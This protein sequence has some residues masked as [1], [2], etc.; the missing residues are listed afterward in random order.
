MARNKAIIVVAHQI[1]VIIWHMLTTGKP[2]HDLGADYYT[3]RLDPTAKPDAWS[4]NS[5]P[6]ATQSPSNPPP[7]PQPR[8]PDPATHLQRQSGSARRCAG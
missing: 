3:T 2:Y 7:N 6:W 4:P 8:P 5:P 1:L